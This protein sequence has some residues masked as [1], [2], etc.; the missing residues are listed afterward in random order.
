[1]IISLGDKNT[2]DKIHHPFALKV[3]ER[4]GIQDISK[5]N[6]SNIQ[7]ANNQHQAKWRETESNPTTI[8]EKTRLPTLSISIHYSTWSSSQN[9]KIA[10]GGQG[11]T[12]WEGRIQSTA[13]CWWYNSIKKWPQKFYLHLIN[14]FSKVSGYKINWKKSV[15]LN[16]TDD[17]LAKKL[18]KQ[19]LLQYPRII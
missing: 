13:I 12:K 8:R 7:Q 5:H 1:M 2:F 17:K 6:K 10:K 4:L 3:S 19:H 9:T 15:T 18:G 11:D 14:T 16:Y